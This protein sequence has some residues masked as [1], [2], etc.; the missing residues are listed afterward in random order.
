MSMTH[1]QQTEPERQTYVP[2]SRALLDTAELADT[3]LGRAIVALGIVLLVVAAVL[4]A[5][6]LG[7]LFA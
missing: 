5:V 1:N 4:S 3:R 2:A 6:W 7:G